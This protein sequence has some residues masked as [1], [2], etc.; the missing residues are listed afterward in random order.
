MYWLTT[1]TH[2]KHQMLIERGLRPKDYEERIERNWRRQVK[3]EDVVIHLG[4]LAWNGG[5]EKIEGLPG[6]KWFVRGNHDGRSN[7]WYLSHGW[8]FVADGIRLERHGELV[9]LTHRPQPPDGWWTL[10]IHGHFHDTDFRK[11]EPQIAAYLTP[12]HILIALEKNGYQMESLD[13]L[14]KRVRK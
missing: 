7:G 8:D 2:F 9:L 6:R 4:D 11:H 14:I 13:A 1:D 5:E 12:N 3:P 10:N